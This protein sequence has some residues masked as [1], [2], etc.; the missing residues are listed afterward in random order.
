VFIIITLTSYNAQSQTSLF[1]GTVKIKDKIIQG[2]FEIYYNDSLIKN[3]VFAPYG[4]SPTAFTEINQNNNELT[5]LW[6]FDQSI[7][8]CLLSKQDRSTFSGNCKCEGNPPIRLIIR[9]FNE[10]DAIL[11]G[12]SIRARAKDIQI[13]DRALELLN[14]GN[15]WDR[16]D[17]RV[18][19]NSSYPYKWSLFCALHQASIDIDSEYRHLSPALQATR[20]AINEITHGKNYAHLLQDYNNEAQSFDSISK[21]L[22]LAK[23]ILRKKIKNNE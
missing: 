13:I 21:V 5:F 11:Q 1:F 9:E 10:E 7:Y 3:I 2:R 4:I 18:C 19:D 15:N 8:Y 20:Q 12:D 17:N 6:N 23:D 22:N 14:N 16:S